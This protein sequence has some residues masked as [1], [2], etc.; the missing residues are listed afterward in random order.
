M[1]NF[2]DSIWRLNGTLS[3]AVTSTAT[4][5]AAALTS[6]TYAVQLA[7]LSA[8]AGA[9]M[10]INIGSAT[11]GV[12]SANTILPANWVQNYKVTPGQTVGA[13]CIN[14]TAA[15]LIVTQLTK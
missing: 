8:T 13:M 4:A 5:S 14:T 10:F 15:T 6:E 7:F 12:S 1:P 9:G 11:V 3:V 2:D